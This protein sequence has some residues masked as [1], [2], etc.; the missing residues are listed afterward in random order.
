MKPF[1]LPV[2]VALILALA[3]LAVAQTLPSGVQRVTSVEGI[4]EYR[5]ANGLRVLLFPD[6]TKQTI[7]VNIT[8]LVGSR[9]ENYGET[10]MAHL[11]EHLLFKGTP[12]HPDIPKELTDHG[13]RPNGTTW[14]DRTN[15]FETF[16]ATDANLEWALD[17]E[18]DRM[19]NSFVAKKD[20]DSEMTVVR[21]EFEAGEND[22]QSVL[23]DRV[24]STAFLWHNYG[25]STVGARAD[26]ENVNI[27]RLQ[28][29]Y[30]NYYQPDNAVLL[31]AGKFD[32]PKTLALVHKFFSP[33][34]RPTRRLQPTYT[35]EP[36]QDGERFVELR[37]VGEVQSVIA[38][39]HLPPGSHEDFAAASL[40]AQALST[41]P[42]GRLYKA[43]VETKKATNVGGFTFA[44]KEPGMALFMAQV[45]TEN[46]IEDARNTMLATLDE[47][48]AKPFTADEVER[49]RT[50]SLKN[51][52][53]TINSSDRFGLT[54]S[55]WIAQGDW[56]LFFV[57][58]DRIRKV[59]TEAVQAAAVKY[60]KPSN[61]TVGVFIPTKEAPERAEIPAPPDVDALVK[62]YK[63]DVMVSQG[64]AFDPTPANIDAR[65]R[66]G[67]VAGIK[68][69]YLSKKTRG[70]SVNAVLRLHTGDEKSLMNQ[71][72]PGRLAA[73]MLM[74]GTAKRTR[75]QI[76]D[77]LDKLKARVSVG[78]GATGINVSIETT[79]PNLPAV[80]EIVGEVLR[81]PSFP[82]TEFEQLRQQMLAGVENQKSEPQGVVFNAFMRHMSPYPK[83]DVRYTPTFDEEIAE[84]KA[85][86]LDDVKKF[87]AGFYGIARSEMTVIGD[88]DPE[89]AQQLTSKLF[90]GWKSPRPFAKVR[91]P[92]RK[93]APLNQSFETPDK[94]N[95]FFVAGMPIQ[96]TDTHADY[97]AMVLANYIIGGGMNSRLFARIRGKEGL[98]YGVG[99]QFQVAPEEDNAMFVTF[100][101]SAPQNAPKVEASF[102]DEIGKILKEG[103]TDA[104]V[105]AAKQSWAQA[106]T[107]SRAQDRELAGRL[108]MHS[109]YN[110]TMAWDADLERKMQA[111]TPAQI[112]E[113]L[114]RHLDPAALTVMKGGDFKKAGVAP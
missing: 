34:P 74:R 12:R 48:K 103:F 2:V 40:A 66:R 80:L 6:P 9:H 109:H 13:T 47:V 52:E 85:V 24:I 95:A 55:E 22:P 73:S 79:R 82:E 26:I 35:V 70:D 38:A 17:L 111:L 39:Y 25:N 58:R 91:S 62:D 23:L 65:T 106:Q 64:E 77:D 7:T 105:S 102:K 41:T 71:S 76:Q 101:I 50:Q 96:I 98:S 60:L 28:A 37:R 14:Y 68:I 20:L 83:G 93:I 53:L 113:A 11:L 36:T 112:V 8:Y 32:E 33:I 21:N 56:R 46:S 43:L 31:V 5:L 107:V 63:G 94:A 114:R 57:N 16:Q 61:R 87:Y 59:S 1:R 51:I 78:G 108:T 97:P 90:G 19:V 72:I 110:R 42:A 81:Q 15:Y 30:K 44:L 4:T 45:R 67:E 10:G 54:L 88:F 84:L 3:S 75:Q 92:Y 89:Q 27:E 86:T 99:S 100:A 104:E 69:N 18:A 49:V 29:F